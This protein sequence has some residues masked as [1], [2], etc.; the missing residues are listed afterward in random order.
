[1][2][3]HYAAGQGLNCV[4]RSSTDSH[5]SGLAGGAFEVPPEAASGKGKGQAGLSMPPLPSL[6][7]K[8]TGMELGGWGEWRL[9]SFPRVGWS[10]GYWMARGGRGPF[11]E[12]LNI[13][14]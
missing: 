6:L 9:Q 2:F 11:L 13:V 1:M 14:S 12:G 5:C 10:V 8:P 7:P 3:L 4:L